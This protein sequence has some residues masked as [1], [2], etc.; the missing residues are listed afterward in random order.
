MQIS[1]YRSET[2]ILQKSRGGGLKSVNGFF[3][4][5]CKFPF[6]DLKREFYKNLGE[7][8]TKKKTANRDLALAK[9]RPGPSK[10]GLIETW[11]WPN[12]D[13]ALAKSANRDLALATSRPGPSKNR[14][15]DTWPWPNRDLALVK[16]GQSRPGPDQIDTWPWQNRPIET[17]PWP[18]RDLALVKIGQSRPGPP[19]AVGPT[20]Q[21]YN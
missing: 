7:G 8:Q 14:P 12:R 17:R 4:L 16:M 20:T 13:L 10:N 5:N 15:I 18:R 6:T 3:S 21:K 9:S 2:R 19:G 1:I 11:P